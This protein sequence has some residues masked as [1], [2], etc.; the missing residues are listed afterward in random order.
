VLEDEL[1]LGLHCIHDLLELDIVLLVMSEELL[2]LLLDF[3]TARDV[4]FQI[5]NDIFDFRYF[6][7]KSLVLNALWLRLQGFQ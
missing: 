4:R 5:S 1:V 2:V 7:K 6:L 3:I